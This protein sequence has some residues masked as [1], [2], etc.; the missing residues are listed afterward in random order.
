MRLKDEIELILRRAGA[1]ACGAVEAGPVDEEEMALYDRWLAAGNAAG[2]DYLHNY[3]ELRRDPRMLLPGA[4]SLISCAFSFAPAERRTLPGHISAYAY[5]DDYHD[6]LRKRL[7]S[8]CKLFHAAG[9]GFRVCIDSAPVRERYWAEKAGIGCRTRSGMLWVPGAGTM[10]FLAE[11][12][13]TK[14]IDELSDGVSEPLENPCTSCGACTGGCPGGALRPDGTIDARRCISYLTIEHR[15]P[16]PSNI[17]DYIFGCDCCLTNCP[18]NAGLTPTGIAEFSLRP[19]I[20]DLT[21]ASLASMTP[22]QIRENFRRSPLLR[23]FR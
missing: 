3:P 10:V 7:K 18:L 11:I 6:V 23:R 2:M 9:E 21:R 15:G 22:E 20:R 16:V 17:D 4:R 1:A 19:E 12:L 5:G 13:T 14:G 8:A